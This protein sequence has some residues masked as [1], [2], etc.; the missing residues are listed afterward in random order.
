MSIVV[1]IP[2]ILS[3]SANNWDFGFPPKMLL[4]NFQSI[5]V[6]FF[7]KIV[8]LP[9]IDICINDLTK[10]L[11]SKDRRPKCQNCSITP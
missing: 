4:L 2:G 10:L 1:V 5:L 6:H 7:I 3:L 9:S 8:I 11:V